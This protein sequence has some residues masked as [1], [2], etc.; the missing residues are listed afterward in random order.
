M[1]HVAACSQDASRQQASRAMILLMTNPL[2]SAANST[3]ELREGV[4]G[5]DYLVAVDFYINETHGTRT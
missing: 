4:A 2:R 5:L 1:I 3:K